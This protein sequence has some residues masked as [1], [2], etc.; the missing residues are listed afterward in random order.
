MVTNLHLEVEKLRHWL[1]TNRW[2]DDYD[3]WWAEGGVI[4]VF[5]EF[6]SRVPPGDWSDD[7]VTDILYVLEQ[8]STEYAAELAT[9]TEEMA[10]AIAEH[11]LAR[12]GIASD[13]IAEQL[14]N[15]VQRRADAEALLMRF[16]Q[17][18][19]ERTRR[20]AGL[21]LARLRFSD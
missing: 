10:L 21:S 11:S 16:A 8:S 12:G 7:D 5:Q 15:C 18:E 13:D 3:V 6:L 17:D 9:R 4:G 2:V 14:G 19:H 1:T 20:V